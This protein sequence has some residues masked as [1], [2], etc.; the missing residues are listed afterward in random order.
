MSGWVWVALGVLAWAGLASALALGLSATIRLADR[1]ERH[2]LADHPPI[3][4]EP[5]PD[6]P[7]PDRP[8]PDRPLPDRP[9]RTQ[10]RRRDPSWPQAG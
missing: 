2:R 10:A 7:L 9:A 1:R 3:P 8:L 5:L 4:D 6:R